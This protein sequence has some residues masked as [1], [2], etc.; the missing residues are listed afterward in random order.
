LADFAKRLDELRYCRRL[1][2]DA[3]ASRLFDDHERRRRLGLLDEYLAFVERRTSRWGRSYWH[4][5]WTPARLLSTG[6]YHR[7]ARGWLSFAKDILHC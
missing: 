3:A 6:Q 5:L 7:F 1:L 2:Q 4:R